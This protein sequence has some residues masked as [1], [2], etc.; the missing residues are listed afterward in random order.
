MHI[1]L[2]SDWT[3][4]LSRFLRD[5]LQ[6]VTDYYHVGGGGTAPGGVSGGTSCVGGGGGGLPCGGGGNTCIGSSSLGSNS[7]PEVELHLKQWNY[8]SQLARCLFEVIILTECQFLFIDI[9]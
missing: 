9:L 7:S 5:Q 2:I 3:Q 6:K 4:T 1:Y 8:C